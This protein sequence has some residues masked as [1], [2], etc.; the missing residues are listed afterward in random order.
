MPNSISYIFYLL[1]SLLAQPAYA[2]EIL[3]LLELPKLNPIHRPADF[4][5][6]PIK[7]YQKPDLNSRADTAVEESGISSIPFE[8]FDWILINRRQGE[9]YEVTYWGEPRWIH[10]RDWGKFQSFE[11]I[12]KEHTG[13][14]FVSD[15]DGRVYSTPNG[16]FSTV[17]STEDEIQVGR[18]IKVLEMKVVKG[19]TWVKIELYGETCA[20]TSKP[21][22][23]TG[24]IPTHNE[25]QKQ[26]VWIQGL[27]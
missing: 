5:P 26:I 13:K 21:P 9:F 11:R 25:K 15:W 23:K 24:W 14:L 16:K 1:F 6:T 7:L 4:K 8:R 27:C 3:G 10:K 19:Q 22:V 18:T 17:K 2:K 12:L 20:G